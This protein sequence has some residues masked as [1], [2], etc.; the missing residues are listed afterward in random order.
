MHRPW[1]A[2]LRRRQCGWCATSAPAAR[3]ACSCLAPAAA[4]G[5][6]HHQHWDIEEAFKR[7]KSRMHREAVPGLSQHAVLNDVAT[8][9]LADKIAAQLCGATEPEITV[10]AIDV[11]NAT[12]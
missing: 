2:R 9:V 8:K 10:P 11:V 4:F 7:L 1:V 3:C 12:A 5:P 6:H